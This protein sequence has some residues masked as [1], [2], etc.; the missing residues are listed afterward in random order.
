MTDFFG[1][2]PGRTHNPVGY[3]SLPSVCLR[4]GEEDGKGA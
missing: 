4:G 1:V 2:I 3:C